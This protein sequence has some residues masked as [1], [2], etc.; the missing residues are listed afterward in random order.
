METHVV[1]ELAFQRMVTAVEKVRDRLRRTAEALEQAQIPYAVV[2][3]NAVADP[4]SVSG[5]ASYTLTAG[6]HS[7]QLDFF[8][9][10]ADGGIFFGWDPAGGTDFDYI[11]LANVVQADETAAD[12]GVRDDLVI[13]TFGVSYFSVYGSTLG[14]STMTSFVFPLIS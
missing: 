4:D 3:G 5:T 13:S 12:T 2:E 11:P 8:Q 1:S 6:Y 9:A 10:D 14:C 7:L